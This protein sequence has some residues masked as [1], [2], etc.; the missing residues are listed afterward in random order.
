MS[1]NKKDF[2]VIMAMSGMRVFKAHW[3]WDHRTE[4]VNE[5]FCDRHNIKMKMV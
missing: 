2:I 4:M 3:F 5:R 1:D